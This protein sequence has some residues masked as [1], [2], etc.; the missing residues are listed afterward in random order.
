MDISLI[1]PAVATN[2]A[3]IPMSDNA[4]PMWDL[5]YAHQIGMPA[6][7]R[8]SDAT[9]TRRAKKGRKRETDAR[10]SNQDD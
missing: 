7:T 3:V 10:R 8:K 6:A 1:D 9:S 4:F 2:D 5:V